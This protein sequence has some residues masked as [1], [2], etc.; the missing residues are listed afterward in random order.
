LELQLKSCYFHIADSVNHDKRSSKTF[1]LIFNF[2][3]KNCFSF[4]LFNVFFSEQTV[5]VR[6]LSSQL[7][8][9]D[10]CSHLCSKFF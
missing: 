4:K 6:V 9:D 8:A 5:A 1:F 3:Q 10:C 2:A 7:S